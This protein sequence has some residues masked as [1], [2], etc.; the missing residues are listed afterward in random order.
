MSKQNSSNR[1][2]HVATLGKTVGLRGDMKL[3]IQSDFPEQFKDGATFITKGDKKVK[4]LSINQDKSMVQ[5]DGYMS[6]ESAKALTNTKLFTTY[7]DTRENCNLNDGEFFWFDIVGCK[8]VE[9][10]KV[11]GE[12]SEIERISISDYLKIDTD[13]E[14]I[15][16]GEVK[17]FLVPYVDHFVKNVD[18]ESKTIEVQ[19][20][21]DILQAS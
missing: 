20:A 16:A 6:V 2:L 3:H 4:I 17:T 18:L 8:I 15:E 21:L 9:D 1:L 10:G 14:L 11:L 5:I 12:V 7:E 13:S 19:G